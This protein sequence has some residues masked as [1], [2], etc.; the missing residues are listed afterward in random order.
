MKVE[1][2][3]KTTLASMCMANAQTF[4][5]FFQTKKINMISVRMC[6]HITISTTFQHLTRLLAYMHFHSHAIAFFLLK[7]NR[8]TNVTATNLG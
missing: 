5:F 7:I 6:H 4:G 8:K 2:K 3:F 1:K